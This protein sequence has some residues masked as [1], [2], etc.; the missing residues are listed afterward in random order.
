MN[1]KIAVTMLC[2]LVSA[3]TTARWLETSS[4]TPKKGAYCANALPAG[5]KRDLHGG[6]CEDCKSEKEVARMNQ[7]MGHRERQTKE[8]IEK[9]KPGAGLRFAAAADGCAGFS[10]ALDFEEKPE[11][12]DTVVEEK[13]VLIFISPVHLPLLKGSR[14]DFADSLQGGSFRIVNP[15][16]KRTCK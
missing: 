2:I 10:Y 1:Q 7:M 13:G 9:E 8:E 12:N 11:A 4:Q 3:G 14:I 6:M 16:A 15:N 5:E